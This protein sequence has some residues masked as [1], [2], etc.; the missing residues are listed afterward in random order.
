MVLVDSGAT[1]SCLSSKFVM[2][3]QAL[4]PKLLPYS[5]LVATADRS[6]FS[7]VDI[8]ST[9]ELGWKRKCHQNPFLILYGNLPKEC[10]MEMDLLKDDIIHA[11]LHRVNSES[12]SD[13]VA[14]LCHE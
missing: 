5:H 1:T 13:N 12:S 9:L 8:I 10:I 14:L 4:M 6:P 2:A 7:V 3:H 11:H